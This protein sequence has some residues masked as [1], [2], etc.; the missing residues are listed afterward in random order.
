MKRNFLKKALEGLSITVTLA[1]GIFAAGCSGGKDGGFTVVPRTDWQEMGL[2]GTPKQ[3]VLLKNRR[4]FTEYYWFNTAGR[5]T[6]YGERPAIGREYH[7]FPVDV[8]TYADDSVT[9]VSKTSYRYSKNGD[10]RIT[11]KTETEYDRWGNILREQVFTNS[12]TSGEPEYSARKPTT[13]EYRLTEKRTYEVLRDSVLTQRIIYDQYHNPLRTVIY[14]SDGR[15]ANVR[16]NAYHYDKDG[17]MV[18]KIEYEDNRYDDMPGAEMAATPYL[19][20]RY[21]YDDGGVFKGDMWAYAES[22]PEGWEKNVLELDDELF[23]KRPDPM[24]RVRDKVVVTIDPTSY[25]RRNNWIH[26]YQEN[27]QR[28]VFRYIDYWDETD[29]EPYENFDPDYD[30]C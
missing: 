5:L 1:L 28:Y 27:P 24:V 11:S 6:E 30:G 19:L 25:D 14:D 9:L 8:Y 18:A 10:Y 13:Y 3:I 15:I 20:W 16:R 12:N 17:L 4:D 7:L 29:M 26:I 2:R 22:L 23:T 21:T